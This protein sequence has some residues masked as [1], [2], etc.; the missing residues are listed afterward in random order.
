MNT[1]VDFY[2][3]AESNP[4][5]KAELAA[6][7]KTL[8]GQNPD[9]ATV[10]SETIRIAGNHGIHLEAADFDSTE[11]ALDESELAAVAGGAGGKC[12]LMGRVSDGLCSFGGLD[13]EEDKGTGIAGDVRK[14][15]G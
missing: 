1:I 9:R 8:A 5:L 10:M 2:K 13:L 3:K 14:T 7:N 6:A 11:E 12:W 4:A 15:E